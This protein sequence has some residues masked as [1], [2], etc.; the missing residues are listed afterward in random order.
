MGS[1]LFRPMLLVSQALS[2]WR[3]DRVWKPLSSSVGMSLVLLRMVMRL[4][5]GKG[6]G[7][8]GQDFLMSLADQMGGCETTAS[9]HRDIFVGIGEFDSVSRGELRGRLR[10]DNLEVLLMSSIGILVLI[11]V[12]VMALRWLIDAS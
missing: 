5:I 12:C 4:G 11:R 8:W 2:L 1:E 3:A 10:S 6:D 9:S 7:D